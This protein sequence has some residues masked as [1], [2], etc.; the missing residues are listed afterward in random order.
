MPDLRARVACDVRFLNVWGA[1]LSAATE[2]ERNEDL[3][4]PDARQLI[5][6]VIVYADQ[7]RNEPK[8]VMMWLVGLL[9][10]PWRRPLTLAILPCAS[11]RRCAETR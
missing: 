11:L 9:R 2:S 3:L 5:C 10:P 4:S 6:G 8:A 7:L 1:C